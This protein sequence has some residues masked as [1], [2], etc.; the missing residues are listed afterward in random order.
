M[1]ASKLL[2]FQAKELLEDLER[3]LQVRDYLH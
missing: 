2:H 3:L 1:K